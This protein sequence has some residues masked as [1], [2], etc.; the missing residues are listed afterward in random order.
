MCK[1]EFGP[2]KQTHTLQTTSHSLFPFSDNN[3]KKFRL[4]DIL[5]D[6]LHSKRT[7]VMWGMILDCNL[8]PLLAL[9]LLA[10]EVEDFLYTAFVNYHGVPR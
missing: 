1:L 2:I 8:C 6:K 9:L 10:F 4:Y 7:L 3:S 5:V